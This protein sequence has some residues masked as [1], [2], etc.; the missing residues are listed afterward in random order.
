MKYNCVS[1]SKLFELFDILMR[2]VTFVGTLSCAYQD[3]C[4]KVPL[5]DAK[6]MTSEE[7]V[8]DININRVQEMAD[9]GTPFDLQRW[10]SNIC[11]NCWVKRAQDT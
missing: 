7:Q 1:S 10:S 4:N 6:E 8:T 11:H 3:R 2:V 5:E 9:K